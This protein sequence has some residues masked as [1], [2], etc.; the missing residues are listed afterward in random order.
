[1]L[2]AGVLASVRFEQHSHIWVMVNGAVIGS[3]NALFS[4]MAQY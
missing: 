4:C 3:D 1:M 2:M